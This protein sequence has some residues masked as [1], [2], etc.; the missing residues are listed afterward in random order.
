SCSTPRIPL[1]LEMR[2]GARAERVFLVAKDGGSAAL[3]DH[4]ASGGCAVTLRP[5][6]G[7]AVIMLT[8]GRTDQAVIDPA[9]IPATMAGRHDGKVWNALFAVA[10]ARA[11]G[12]P[13]DRIRHGLSSFKP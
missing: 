13:P 6:P 10:I 5:A 11:M 4:L 8:E 3:R 1:C 12:A 9:M 7:G 2:R